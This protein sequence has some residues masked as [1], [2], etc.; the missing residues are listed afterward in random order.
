MGRL[1]MLFVSLVFS[2]K[3]ARFGWLWNKAF[4]MSWVF[5]PMQDHSFLS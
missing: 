1:D 3:K 2:S 4:R 5:I